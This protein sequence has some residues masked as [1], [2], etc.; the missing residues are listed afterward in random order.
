MEKDS[1]LDNCYTLQHLAVAAKEKDG[2]TPTRDPQMHIL[3]AWRSAAEESPLLVRPN[4]WTLIN[5]YRRKN[6]E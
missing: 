6:R 2:R 3:K 4:S 1:S 5:K